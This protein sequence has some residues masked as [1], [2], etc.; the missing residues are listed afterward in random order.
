V[1]RRALGVLFVGIAAALVFVAIA[2]FTGSGGGIGRVIVGIAS[3]ALAAWM[4]SLAASA[5]RR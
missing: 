5:F 1:Q 3:L 4:A 2:A